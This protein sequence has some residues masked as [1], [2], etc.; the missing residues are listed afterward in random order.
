MEKPCKTT[1][2]SKLSNLSDAFHK[3]DAIICS[4]DFGQTVT[5]VFPIIL[6]IS[7]KSALLFLVKL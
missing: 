4:F 7:K 1:I 6:L 2:T 3:A 5:E